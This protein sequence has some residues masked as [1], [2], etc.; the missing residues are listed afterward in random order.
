MSQGRIRERYE[1]C[2][3]VNRGRF[4][5]VRLIERLG[6]HSPDPGWQLDTHWLY[7]GL[8]R[9]SGHYRSHIWSKLLIEF[10]K[11]E[12]TARERMILGVE[13]RPR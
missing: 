7:P 1:V 13:G 8:I 5:S 11:R 6:A 9:V 10:R 12:A 4:D 2:E 3:I